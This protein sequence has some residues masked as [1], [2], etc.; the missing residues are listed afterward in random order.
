M[1]CLVCV[2]CAI[3][4]AVAIWYRKK[5]KRKIW[6]CKTVIVV[7]GL[8]MVCSYSFLIQMLFDVIKNDAGYFQQQIDTLTELNEQMESWLEI[9]EDKLSDNPQLLNHLKEYLNEEIS[10]NNEEIEI[11]IFK[12]EVRV[13]QYRWLLYFKYY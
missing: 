8:V 7:C 9:V 3:G 6:L 12:Q 10:S 11:C 13:P 2:L 5:Y 4:L 1:L